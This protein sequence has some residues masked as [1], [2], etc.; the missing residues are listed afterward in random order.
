ME[1]AAL[2]APKPFPL[3]LASMAL[4]DYQTLVDQ[5]AAKGV[6]VTTS[7]FS[8]HAREFVR[9]PD[10]PHDRIQTTG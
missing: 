9:H 2:V 4:P 3:Q 5:G 7:S 10:K 6:F 8:S 1:L